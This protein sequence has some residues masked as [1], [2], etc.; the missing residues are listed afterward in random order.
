MAVALMACL[1]SCCPLCSPCNQQTTNKNGTEKESGAPASKEMQDFL[2]DVYTALVKKM[3]AK[4]QPTSADKPLPWGFVPIWSMD[5]AATHQKAAAD[6]GWK[7]I[8]DGGTKPPGALRTVQPPAY[9][10]DLH[11]VIEHVHGTVRSAFRKVVLKDK[12]PRA[13]IEAYWA[14]LQQL[15]YSHVTASS[16][17]RD[18][19]SLAETYEQV[20]KLDGAY[21]AAKYR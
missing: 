7:L 17:S 21:P 5:N 9:S 4:D 16:V 11:K 3:A 20:I 19:A 2:C 8:S 12:Q 13:G 10:P 6:K 18:V 15:F 14:L 1:P